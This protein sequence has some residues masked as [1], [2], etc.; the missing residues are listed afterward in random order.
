MSSTSEVAPGYT[1]RLPMSTSSKVSRRSV[2]FGTVAA[3]VGAVG[4]ALRGRLRAVTQLPSFTAT[5][6]LV[7]H[8]PVR[9]RATIHIGRGAS[10]AGNVDTVIDKLG[11]ISA[12]VGADDVVVIKVSAQW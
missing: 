1:G 10:P 12:V 11:G 8:D 6:P 4:F 5:P 7:P 9:D 2:V 3:G